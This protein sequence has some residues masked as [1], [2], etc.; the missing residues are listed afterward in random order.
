M[1]ASAQ[2]APSAAAEEFKEVREQVR[3]LIC[4]A[5]LVIVC[6]PS[7]SFQMTIPILTSVLADMI[8]G[9]S[10]FPQRWWLH[11][12]RVSSCPTLPLMFSLPLAFK[13]KAGWCCHV[14]LSS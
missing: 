2:W 7:S 6:F 11:G 5:V 10:L 3:V 12:D 1:Q 8:P 4:F 13:M 9:S 14:P